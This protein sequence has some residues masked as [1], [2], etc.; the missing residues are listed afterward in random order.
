MSNTLPHQEQPSKLADLP[1]PRLR[2]YPRKTVFAEKLEAIASLGMTSSRMKDYFDLLALPRENAM[3]PRDLAQAIGGAFA[4]RQTALPDGLTDGL[5]EG[6]AADAEKGKL[7]QAFLH[8]NRL[9]APALGDV[10]D[11]GNDDRG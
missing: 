6:F 3:N 8:R 11:V 7:W 10:A 4:R 2:V 9:A 1:A 5:T